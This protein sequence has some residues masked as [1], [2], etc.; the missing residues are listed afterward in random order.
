MSVVGECSRMPSSPETHAFVDLLDAGQAHVARD[1][2]E[3][4]ALHGREVRLAVAV[5][6]AAGQGVDQ[7]AELRGHAQLFFFHRVRVVDHEQQIDVVD[8]VREVTARAWLRSCAAGVRGRSRLRAAQA[9]ERNR[10]RHTL[11]IEHVLVGDAARAD[12]QHQ[13]EHNA[14]RA[15]GTRRHSMIGWHAGGDG[16]RAGGLHDQRPRRD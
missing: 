2:A 4:Q 15:C 10:V 11:G 13:A 5:A 9:L 3:V 8:R 7:A 6:I 12:A 16:G 14:R 1:D